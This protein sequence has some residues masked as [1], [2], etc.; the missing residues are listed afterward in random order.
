MLQA[1]ALY[2]TPMQQ[3]QKPSMLVCKLQ[4]RKMRAYWSADGKRF[5]PVVL[6]FISI[7]NQQYDENTLA[8]RVWQPK[9]KRDHKFENSMHSS[10]L[11]I[12]DISNLNK[13]LGLLPYTHPLPEKPGKLFRALIRADL[14]ALE[15]GDTSMIEDLGRFAAWPADMVFM[16]TAAPTDAA[17]RGAERIS[18][19]IAR[20]SVENQ[21]YD[22][23]S[24]IERV[25]V[26]PRPVRQKMV[27][28]MRTF[29]ITEAEAA[30]SGASAMQVRLLV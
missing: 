16:D 18:E 13:L 22:T 19:I 14:T 29:P 28:S 27:A 26:L 11:E 25:E 8:K 23:S 1:V 17:N 4:G 3:T 20:A 12:L 7:V 6:D 10:G 15:N 21:A 5:K 9:F 24:R 30:S 2:S